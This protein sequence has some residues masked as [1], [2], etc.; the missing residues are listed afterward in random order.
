MNEITRNTMRIL[1]LIICLFSIL[2]SEKVHVC[3]AKEKK[4]EQQYSKDYKKYPDGSPEAVLTAFI[5]SDLGDMDNRDIDERYPLWWRLTE[6]PGLAGND[7]RYLQLTI[8]S[9]RICE[10]SIDTVN[11]AVTVNLEMD[12]RY[13]STLGFDFKKWGGVPVM[14]N[15][16]EY[17][18]NSEQF[19]KDVFGE[20]AP[21]IINNEANNFYSVQKDK[22][23]WLFPVRMKSINNK[24]V[25]SNSTI[26]IQATNIS[27]VIH[28]IKTQIFKH[29]SVKEVCSGNLSF[30]KYVREKRYV[31]MVSMEETGTDLK[32]FRNH[33]CTPNEIE[34]IE[35]SIINFGKTIQQLKTESD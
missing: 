25:I 4:S 9:Y 18:T 35:Q 11:G 5:E 31:G 26:P 22:R 15:G 17:L 30:Q 29:Q 8:T 20:K 23:K 16:I 34:S 6:K 28:V 19:I 32:A 14:V 2:F 7:K 13:L 10:T 12:V 24:W 33:F 21:S 3:H 1:L 27:M